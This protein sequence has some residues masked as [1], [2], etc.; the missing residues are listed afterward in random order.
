MKRIYEIAGST[1]L[2]G[3]MAFGASAQQLVNGGF[4]GEW[5]PKAPWTSDGNDKAEGVMPNPDDPYGDGVPVPLVSPEG[6]TVA[7]VIGMSGLGATRVGYSVEGR[8]EGN[9]AFICNSPNTFMATQIVPG[10]I[11]L[12]TTWS[13]SVMGKSNDGGTFG[14]VEFTHRPDAVSFYYKRARG[15]QDPEAEEPD[16]TIKP[17]ETTSIVAYL[18]KGTWTQ[19]DVPGNIGFAEALL[20]KVDMVNRER[21]ILGIETALGGEVTASEDAELIAVLNTT[22]T[23]NADDWTLFE[24][25]L[26]YKS[27]ATPEMFNIILAAGDYFGGAE[28]VGKNNSLTVDDVKLVYYSRLK[29]IAFGGTAVELED[30]RF[31]YPVDAA[32]PASADAVVYELLG[33]SAVADVDID[34][35]NALVTVTVSNVDADSDGEN[36]HVYTFR[37][38]AAPAGETKS[39]PGYLTVDMGTGDISGNAPATVFVTPTSATTCNF[40]LPHLMLGEL[41]ELGD[42]ALNGVEMSTDADGV[43]TYTGKVDGMK[44]LDDQIVANVSLNGTIN[45]ADVVDFKIDVLWLSEMG[46]MP[47][48]VTFKSEK[49]GIVNVAVDEDAEIEYYN[50]HGVRVNSADLPAGVYVRRQGNVVDKVVVR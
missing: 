4:E 49:A 1:L 17:D 50:I 29:S 38:N 48:A 32:V 31:D 11:T 16:E 36:S 15:E 39:Y 43:T 40:L 23:E 9:A 20:T 25:P 34:A 46:D 37:F 7:N 18:W 44:L 6:W 3:C 30:G 33:H 42:I 21:N 8:G 47:I 45:A 22:I 12:G 14:G 41:G 13:T 24:Q 27:D 5:Q 35:A 19:K 10:Y 28:V 2:V 26:E